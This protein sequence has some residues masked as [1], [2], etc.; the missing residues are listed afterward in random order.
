M[1]RSALRPCPHPGCN[2][3]IDRKQRHCTEHERAA[4]AQ[5]PKRLR[6][7][8]LQERN[9]RLFRANPLCVRCVE[10]GGVAPVDDWD[11]RVPL[12]HGGAET[13]YRALQKLIE[14]TPDPWQHLKYPPEPGIPASPRGAIT[15]AAL[16]AAETP[17]LLVAGVDK[18]ARSGWQAYAPLQPVARQWVKQAL[19]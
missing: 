5:K 10:E 7:R 2:K 17:E 18:W 16:R 4:E 3:L 11:H 1:P 9:A 12:E 8:K 19:G 13:G 15:V 6:G 14:R